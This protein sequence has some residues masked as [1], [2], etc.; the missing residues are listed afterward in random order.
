[1][2]HS[3]ESLRLL[4]CHWDDDTHLWPAMEKTFNVSREKSRPRSDQK[5]TKKLKKTSPRE[6]IAKTYRYYSFTL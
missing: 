1:M 6:Q 3:T 2:S 4:G 5:T